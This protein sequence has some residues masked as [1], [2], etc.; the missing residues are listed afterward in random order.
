MPE[1]E[2]GSDLPVVVVGDVHG[3]IERMFQ[4]LQPYPAESW[5]TLFLGDL[6]DGG[7]F[8]VG[9]LRYA[10]DRPNSTLILGNH[11][12]LMLWALAEPK[13]VSLWAS[14]GGKPHELQELRKDEA[15][16]AWIKE[17][18]LLVKLPDGTLV[19]H[20]DTDLYGRL[21]GRDAADPVGAINAR[22]RGLLD[23]GDFGALW[24]VLAPGRMFRASR[25]R[26][27]AWLRLTGAR[28]LVH[29]HMPHGRQAPD[30]YHDG[31]AIAFDGGLSRYYGGRY[32][33]RNPPG[34]SVGPLA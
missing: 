12:V 27:E 19:Q 7:D 8:G 14:V 18:R 29:G 16:Q 9:A 1:P 26:L 30:S 34:A 3:D 32:R 20:S 5:Q 25:A 23:L 28:R 6:V 21:A 33:R 13:V 2:P 11:E 10:R 22:A 24:D 15:L 4:A 31:L 17:Q